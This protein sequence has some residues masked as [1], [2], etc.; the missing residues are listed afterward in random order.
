MPLRRARKGDFER[1][2]DIERACFVP[3]RYDAMSPRQLRFH[4][5]SPRSVF[6]VTTG[7]TGLVTGYALGLL[8]KGRGA[9]RFYSLAVAPDVQRGDYGKLL[10]EGIEAEAARRGLGVQCEV[11]ADNE[12][13]KERYAR[14]G[15]APYRSVPDYYPDGAACIKYLKPA[16]A[17]ATTGRR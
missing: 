4:L 9:M 5:S 14:L 11:R 2:M 12:K 7:E 15:Y 6:L 10:F 1:L 16:D 3:P 17:I 8:Q 13:L